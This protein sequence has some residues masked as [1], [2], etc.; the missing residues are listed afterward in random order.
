MHMLN[1]PHTFCKV[2][3]KKK[4][5]EPNGAQGPTRF[6]YF[7]AISNWRTCQAQ[8]IMCID[9]QHIPNIVP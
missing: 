6:C 5:G 4:R 7:T 2:V 9:G 3:S 1:W 8:K